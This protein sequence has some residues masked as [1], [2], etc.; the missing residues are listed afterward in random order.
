MRLRTPPGPPSSPPPNRAPSRPGRVGQAKRL[1]AVPRRNPDPA[2][3]PRGTADGA[4]GGHS[5]GS[6]R[7]WGRRSPR[8]LPG[9]LLL[10]SADRET[11]AALRATALEDVAA[12]LGAHA[13]AG[14]AVTVPAKLC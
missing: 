1:R 12:L 14:A 4:G 6:K 2:P 8:A 5:W 13:L 7:R 9:A 11:L 3:L 10:R